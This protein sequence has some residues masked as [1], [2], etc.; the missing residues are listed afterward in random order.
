MMMLKCRMSL[1]YSVEG[2]LEGR[3]LIITG[4]RDDGR[5]LFPPFQQRSDV[6]RIVGIRRGL[7]FPVR[8][9]WCLMVLLSVSGIPYAVSLLNPEG[10]ELGQFAKPQ[11]EK[12]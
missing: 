11:V 9:L 2:S 5:L 10:L 4:F 6:M 8:Y 3:K 12:L 7:R 1:V